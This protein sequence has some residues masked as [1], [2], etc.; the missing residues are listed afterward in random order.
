MSDIQHTPHSE[1]EH[2]G[3]HGAAGHSAGQDAR[4]AGHGAHGPDA[5]G[6][7]VHG[8]GA[9]GAGAHNHPGPR[10]YIEIAMLLGLITAIEVAL[11]YIPSAR[12]ILVP[13]LLGLSALKFGVVVAFYMHLKFDHRLFT[14]FFVA[15]I[16]LAAFMITALMALFHQH[17][18]GQFH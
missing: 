10:R 6:A 18:S 17:L 9:H 15:F 3:G 16:F 13:A 12:P 11:Y 2:G 1:A 5:H 4:E 7:D 8:A 14:K